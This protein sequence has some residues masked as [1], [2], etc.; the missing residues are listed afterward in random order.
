M[1]LCTCIWVCK[2]KCSMYMVYFYLH[3]PIFTIKTHS[4]NVSKS[5]CYLENLVILR[6]LFVGNSPTEPTTGHNW[7]LSR[8]NAT[9]WRP[10]LQ[11]RQ[12]IMNSRQKFLP[13]SPESLERDLDLKRDLFFLF[14]K[15][16]RVAREIF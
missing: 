3:L 7:L 4:Q 10:R 8:S 2:P 13:R 12:L 15:G 14:P 6:W 5:T 1:F 11:W 16:A 9:P